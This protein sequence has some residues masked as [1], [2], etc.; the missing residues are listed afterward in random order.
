MNCGIIVEGLIGGYMREVKNVKGKTYFLFA[1]ALF[2]IFLLIDNFTQLFLSEMFGGTFMEWEY[3]VRVIS[4][5]IPATLWFCLFWLANKQSIRKMNFN[6]LEC[7][8]KISKRNYC[9]AVAFLILAIFFN[10][11]NWG[12]FKFLVEFRNAGLI[13]FIAQHIYYLAEIVITTV[14]I[15]LFQK[16]C[17]T[18][19]KKENIP[20]GGMIGAL[21]WGL[22][23][24]FT[25]NSLLVGLLGFVYGFGFGTI[26]LIL[27]KNYKMT[28]FFLF[29][30]FVL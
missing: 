6:F 8:E 16:S 17:E 14:L 15:V 26:Y 19:F 3:W 13:G 2:V 10:Y 5:M 28:V 12:N 23:H 20:F 7:S 4:R 11:M 22:V 9:I 29:L 18:W 27:E 30:M 21:T 25:Q 1:I 24:I